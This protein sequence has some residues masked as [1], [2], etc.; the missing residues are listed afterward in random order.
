MRNFLTLILAVLL[1]VSSNQLKQTNQPSK[2]DFMFNYRVENLVEL[3]AV[4]KDEGVT[5]VGEM[6][7]FDYGK[8]AWVLDN[9]GNKIE[10]WEPIDKAFL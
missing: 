9:D 4:L 5:I 7:E 6:E 3:L 10:L 2:K 8:F 1:L